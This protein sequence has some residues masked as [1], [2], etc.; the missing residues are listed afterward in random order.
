MAS[1]KIIKLVVYEILQFSFLCIPTFVVMERFALHL[2]EVQNHNNDITYW[3]IV[4]C[5]IAYVMTVTLAVWVPVKVMI[6]KKRRAFILERKWRPL[7]LIYLLL[8]TLPCFAF[9][10]AASEIR[11]SINPCNSNKF[12]DLP[13]S[14]T[15]TCLILVDIIQKL[16]KYRLKGLLTVQIRENIPSNGPVVSYIDVPSVSAQVRRAQETHAPPQLEDSIEP[17]LAEGEGPE[18][19][20]SISGISLHTAPSIH[21]ISTTSYSSSR[22]LKFIAVKDARAEIFLDCFVFWFDTIEMVR[23]AGT[24]K[25]SCSG[26]V[27]PIY[28]FSFLSLV[29]IILP[30]TSPLLYSLGVMLQDFPFLFIRIPLLAIFPYTT[31]VLYAVKNALVLGTHIYFNYFTRLRLCRTDEQNFS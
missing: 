31:P 15:L 24:E 14:L 11:N 2:K 3:L 18:Y 21:S 6:Y 17:T 20:S 1:G 27:I 29:R 22:T 9:F 30:S 4:S 5:S 10:I 7:M 23:V 16:R 13:V 12:T 25:V 19:P 26:W 28:I 8:T